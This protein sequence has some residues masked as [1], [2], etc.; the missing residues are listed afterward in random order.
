[1]KGRYIGENIR[2]IFE[3]I[4]YLN[5]KNKPGLLLFADYEKAFDS[6]DHDFVVQCLVKY[7]FGPELIQWIKLF[8]NDINTIIINNGHFSEPI[9]IQRGVKQGCPLST[10][11]FILSIEILSNYIEKNENIKGIKVNDLD[12]K[13]TLFADDTTYFIDGTINSFTA[14]INAIQDFSEISGLKLNTQKSTVMRVGSLKHTLIKFKEYK[15]IIW[16]SDGAY[17]HLIS[18]SLMTKILIIWQKTFNKI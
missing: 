2:T 3:T 18:I 12:I 17:K 9:A 1:M 8:Y 10:T 14:L 6:L 5:N 16:T 13:Q 7:N 15:N 4:H 11:L